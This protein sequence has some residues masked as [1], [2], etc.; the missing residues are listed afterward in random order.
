LTQ[1]EASMTN[2]PDLIREVESAL[3]RAPEKSP[4]GRYAVYVPGAV[5]IGTYARKADARAVAARW[6]PV[7]PDVVIVDRGV[8]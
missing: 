7:V 6:T 1:H 5:V 3:T 2:R 8:G 4:S